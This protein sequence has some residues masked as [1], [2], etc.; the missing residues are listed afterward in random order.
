MPRIPSPRPPPPRRGAHGAPEQ[1][2]GNSQASLCEQREGNDTG[3]KKKKANQGKDTTAAGPA[4]GS[5][6]GPTLSSGSP[7]LKLARQLA[8]DRSGPPDRA[9]ASVPQT[10]PRD[11]P[12]ACPE[13]ECRVGLAGR[14]PPEGSGSQ[15]GAPIATPRRGERS[16]ILSPGP[17]EQSMPVRRRPRV[18]LPSARG[19]AS[20]SSAGTGRGGG[21]THP[22]WRW[23]R[24]RLQP[25]S[26]TSAAGAACRGS[27]RRGRQRAWLRA[28]AVGCAR[29]PRRLPR[30][31]LR[32][33]AVA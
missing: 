21:G 4:P 8:G 20:R 1:S 3:R 11:A 17:G 7:T 28:G 12:A 9:R 25:R 23:R 26:V 22:W 33:G 16:A 27:G 31:G 15:N 19:G 18:L 6:P 14:A 5:N 24:R 32:P 10:P 13:R 30:L 29:G 2:P